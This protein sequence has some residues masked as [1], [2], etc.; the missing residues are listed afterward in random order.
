[1]LQHN[2]YN[3]RIFLEIL[4]S[5]LPIS[6]L[7]FTSMPSPPSKSGPALRFQDRRSC[8]LLLFWRP[9]LLWTMLLNLCLLLRP[10][11]RDR[12]VHVADDHLSCKWLWQQRWVI[13]FHFFLILK[14]V[15]LT[16]RGCVED[17]RRSFGPACHPKECKRS[18][19]LD[20]FVNALL[21][22]IM[23]S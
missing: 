20:S 23:N 16:E 3:L 2:N 6:T 10:R 4:L 15:Y 11:L 1:M 13:D 21:W 12:Q 17:L 9:L 18:I 14:A 5:T 7:I 22:V 19:G 8:R